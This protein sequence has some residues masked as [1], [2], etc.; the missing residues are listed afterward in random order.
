MMAK[1][2]IVG[3]GE[4]GSAVK[5]V[6]VAAGV[7]VVEKEVDTNPIV[8]AEPEV[9]TLHVCI[10]FS[11]DFIRGVAECVHSNTQ[12]VFV[13]STVPP[14]T[15][16][17]LQESLGDA[18]DVIHAPVR[19]LHPNLASGLLTFP[20]FLGARNSKIAIDNSTLI[21]RLGILPQV[22]NIWEESELAKVLDTT[23]YGVCIAF[24]DYAAKLSDEVGANFDN[25]MTEYNRSYN[26][27]Y[28]ELGKPEVVRPVLY[29]PQG[30]IGGHCVTPNAKLLEKTFGSHPLLK[31]ILD[32]S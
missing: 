3:L 23:Y 30:A 22:V 4:I 15:C 17:E 14:G 7:R 29:P 18:V 5:E 9:T 1:I 2:G 24:H 28:T 12:T 32:L 11:E 31:A 27:G 6:A 21:T 19:G 16:R 20:M 8:L 25:V 26:E 10:P 13:H